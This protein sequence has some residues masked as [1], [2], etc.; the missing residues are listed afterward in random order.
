MKWELSRMGRYELL[1]AYAQKPHRQLVEANDDNALQAFVKAWGPLNLTYLKAWEGCDSISNYRRERD[2]LQAWVRFL[3][4]IESPEY[5]YD[6][7][8]GL[9][10][11]FNKGDFVWLRHRLG[12]GSLESGFDD[13]VEKRL[14]SATPG[15]IAD[16]CS[17]LAGTFPLLP[18]PHFV[19]DR[20]AKSGPIVR[21]SSGVTSLTTALYWMV[22][23][24][25]FMESPWQFC[26]ECHNLFQ[27]D[28]RHERKFCLPECAHR[29]AAR[30]SARRKREEERKANGTRKTR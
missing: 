3:T 29:K 26:E 5:L 7:I 12:I 30:E 21:A 24:D 25:I 22:W 28:Y 6:S 15:E 4:A 20:T 16:V 23:Q 19:I 17:Y 13:D 14:A 11:L 18:F 1:K 27:P 8:V 2:T 9:L 10:R